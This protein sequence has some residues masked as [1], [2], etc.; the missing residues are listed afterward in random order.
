MDEL[1]AVLNAVRLQ[2]RLYCRLE[3]R[4]PWAMSSQPSPVATFHGV[5]A[6]EAV[7]QINGEPDV[8]LVAGDLAVLCHG[9]GHAIADLSGCPAVDIRS[10]LAGAGGAWLVR[11]GGRGAQTV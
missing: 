7:L 5:V 1:S 2:G 10:V 4:A 3:A 9:S 6:G 8:P 11:C